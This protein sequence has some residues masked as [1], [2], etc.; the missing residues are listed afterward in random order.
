MMKRISYVL[1]TLALAFSPC[2]AAEIVVLKV[3]GK[4]T[5]EQ[6]E[7]HPL[8][9][10]DDLAKV[11][12]EENATVAVMMGDGSTATLAPGKPLPSM[13]QGKK[14]AK[15]ASWWAGLRRSLR[16]YASLDKGQGEASVAMV[17]RGRIGASAFLGMAEEEKNY[18]LPTVAELVFSWTPSV[19]PY[20]FSLADG[21]GNTIVQTQTSEN[22]FTAPVGKLAPG[23]YQ[24][25]IATSLGETVQSLSVVGPNALPETA[26]SIFNA[27]QVPPSAKDR[28]LAVALSENPQWRFMALQWAEKA[29][30][31]KLSAYLKSGKS[32][33]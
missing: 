21:A 22:T 30:D 9:I 16:W 20:A 7:L 13:A 10:V 6:R 8:M 11:S 17:S 28:L 2:G 29:G 4:A 24:V 33:E 25:K 1:L 14:A 18:V 23:D 15:T 19:P 3:E 12:L 26:K 31:G 5:F 27:R 32:Q